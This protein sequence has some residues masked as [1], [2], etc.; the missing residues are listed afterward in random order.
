VR[1]L[2]IPSDLDIAVEDGGEVAP[3][4][5]KPVP[6]LLCAI[7]PAPPSLKP[8]TPASGPL[9]CTPTPLALL[10]EPNTPAP[11]GLTDSPKTPDPPAPPPVGAAEESLLPNTPKFPLL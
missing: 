8:L 3:R 2:D 11:P 5:T 7:T 10:L 9:P 1:K 6:V 4:A